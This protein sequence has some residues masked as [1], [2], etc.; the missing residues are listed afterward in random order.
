MSVA[1]ANSG[2]RNPP[3]MCGSGRPVR[4][5]LTLGILDTNCPRTDRMA[6]EGSWSLHSSN[7][8]MTITVEMPDSTRGCT[9]NLFIWS[10]RDS[11]AIPGSDRT[12]GTRIDRSSVYLR[13][14][15]TARVG[16]MKWRLLRSSKSREQKKEAPSCPFANS[17]SVVVC[18]M[19]LFPVPAN[20]FSQ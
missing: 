7:A 11:W 17:L 12:N 3:W 14:S 8:S 9:I 1:S 19:V 6:E 10:Y 20:P 16:K 2:R 4:K 18:A 15:W 5:N 13:A